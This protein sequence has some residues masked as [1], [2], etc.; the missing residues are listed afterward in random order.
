M[1]GGAIA[2]PRSEPLTWILQSERGNQFEKNLA[3]EG[4]TLDWRELKSWQYPDSPF[5]RRERGSLHHDSVTSLGFLVF[6][7]VSE[8]ERWPNRKNTSDED[9]VIFA[10]FNSP[11]SKRAGERQAIAHYE[12]NV[13]PPALGLCRHWEAKQWHNSRH[14]WEAVTQRRHQQQQYDKCREEDE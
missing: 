6:S 13:L 14:Q 12:N 10:V 5:V 2:I 7:S 1:W 11:L 3:K 9:G 8:I 4:G